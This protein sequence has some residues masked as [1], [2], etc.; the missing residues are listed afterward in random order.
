MGVRR[1]IRH[2]LFRFEQLEIS[3][4]Q[5]GER[6]FCSA[7]ARGRKDFTPAA[8]FGKRGEKAEGWFGIL[9][10]QRERIEDKKIQYCQESVLF[11]HI[12]IHDVFSVHSH[13]FYPALFLSCYWVSSMYWVMMRK[14]S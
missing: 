9:N 6:R 14:R 13:D 12:G 2:V 5:E 3:M 1:T 8:D 10:K 4:F 11:Q 7:A